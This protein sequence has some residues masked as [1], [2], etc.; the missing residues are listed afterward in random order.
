MLIHY[1]TKMKDEPEYV[2]GKTTFCCTSMARLFPKLELQ[3]L[4]EHHEEFFG[5]GNSAI[6]SLLDQRIHY[7]PFCS[8]KITLFETERIQLKKKLIEVWDELS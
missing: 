5:D 4:S 7:C 1:K 8:A 3:R 6:L 2:T